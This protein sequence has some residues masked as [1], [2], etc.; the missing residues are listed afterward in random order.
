M[1]DLFILCFLPIL[2]TEL[3]KGHARLPS[4]AYLLL[5]LSLLFLR[6]GSL[7]FLVALRRRCR[8][9]ALL[10]LLLDLAAVAVLLLPLLLHEV[11]AAEAQLLLQLRL[12]RL[13]LALVGLV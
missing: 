6:L 10:L 11:E 9:L 5:F 13:G 7:L 8:L 4:A 2:D 1:I 12:G 3:S